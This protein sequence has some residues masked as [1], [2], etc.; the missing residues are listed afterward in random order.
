MK[1]L[2]LSTVIV[3]FV[4]G[5]RPNFPN[6]PEY[7]VLSPWSPWSKCRAPTRDLIEESHN[8]DEKTEI[9]C[10]PPLVRYRFREC[11]GMEQKIIKS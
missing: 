7:G 11:R 9:Y 1:Y 8:F 3:V 2:I 10:P 4:S 5:R 6:N